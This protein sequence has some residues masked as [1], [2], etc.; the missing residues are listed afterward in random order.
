MSHQIE[1]LRAHLFATLEAL[2]SKDAPM[3]IERAKAVA[4]VSRAIIDS[5]KVEVD[6]VKVVGGKGTGFITEKPP[7]PG[8]PRLVKGRDAQG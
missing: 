2:R 3:D 8:T 1:D 4:E 5:A 7:V 6:L